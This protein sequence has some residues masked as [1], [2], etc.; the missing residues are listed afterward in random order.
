VIDEENTVVET[1]DYRSAAETRLRRGYPLELAR[2]RRVQMPGKKVNMAMDNTTKEGFT[3][4]ERDAETGWDY[5]GARYYDAGIGKWLSVDPLSHIYSSYSSYNYVLNNPL[6]MKDPDG[7]A[8]VS[9]GIAI[10]IGIGL[11]AK[12]V[13]DIMIVG[14]VV[15]VIY[16][17]KKLIDRKRTK[18]RTEAQESKKKF[19]ERNKPPKT[20]QQKGS[21]N[22][23]PNLNP[24]GPKG[25]QGK[26]PKIPWYLS[27]LQL[28]NPGSSV[29]DKNEN[30]G[31]VTNQKKEKKNLDQLMKEALEEIKKEKEKKDKEKKDKE[32]KGKEK[33][34]KEKKGK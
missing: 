19:K 29:L 21:N 31:S 23:D 20:E 18:V 25:W 34:D 27:I 16:Q 12:V 22:S 2:P 33:K 14:G 13:S 6:N 3:G 7:R 15:V 17:S 26:S 11:A 1:S 10:G 28:L 5:F 32:K 4:K 30:S 8:A 24:N 9:G